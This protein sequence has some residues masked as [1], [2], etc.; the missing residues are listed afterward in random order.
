MVDNL[1]RNI[2]GKELLLKYTYNSFRHMDEFSLVD[3]KNSETNPTMIFKITEILLYGALNNS[4]KQY[5]SRDFVMDYLESKVDNGDEEEIFDLAQ[6][7]M[8]MLSE[9]SFFKRL[10]EEILKQQQEE[11]ET[12]N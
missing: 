7:L 4:R 11:S 8:E 6:T 2:N 9:T 10:Q 12:L 3:V 1:L 5:Y